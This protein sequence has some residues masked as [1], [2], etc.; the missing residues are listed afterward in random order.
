MVIIPK[1]RDLD[2]IRFIIPRVFATARHRF[3]ESYIIYG[4]FTLPPRGVCVPSRGLQ[5]FLPTHPALPSYIP[6][7]R[8]CAKIIGL[9]TKLRLPVPSAL[10]SYASLTTMLEE[11]QSFDYDIDI[12]WEKEGWR[13]KSLDKKRINPSAEI[14]KSTKNP[15]AKRDWN[16]SFR[17]KGDIKIPGQRK[18]KSHEF[19]ISLAVATERKLEHW[20]KT[21]RFD[22]GMEDYCENSEQRKEKYAK[23]LCLTVFFYLLF[24]S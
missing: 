24:L 20:R 12:D 7:R 3:F 6:L 11:E 9:L 5:A 8:L 14:E 21:G 22:A 2:Y 15:T 23:A 19:C 16:K 18:G 1:F 4:N 13:E 17:R 10:L